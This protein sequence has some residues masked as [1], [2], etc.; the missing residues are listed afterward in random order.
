M[1]IARSFKSVSTLCLFALCLM[2]FG[3]L[4][5]SLMG[6]ALLAS[7]FVLPLAAVGVFGWLC[8]KSAFTLR[9]SSA[10]PEPEAEQ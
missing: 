10:E 7:V 2:L 9:K 6:L 8:W 1:A 3:F 4:A 5:P